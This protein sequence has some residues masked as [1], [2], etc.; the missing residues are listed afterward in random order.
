MLALESWR[1]LA[2]EADHF[3]RPEN[4]KPSKR[5]RRAD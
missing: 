2:H 1:H 3:L 5:G 4:G